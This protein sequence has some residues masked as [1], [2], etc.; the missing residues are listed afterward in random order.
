MNKRKII[1]LL[2]ILLYF[3]V[4]FPLAPMLDRINVYASYVFEVAFVTLVYF[5]YRGR[6]RFVLP[7]KQQAIINGV[8]ALIAG[9]VIYTLSTVL[10]L[11]IPFDLKGA[12]ILIFLLLVA[13]LLEEGVFRFAL[14]EP[15]SEFIGDKKWLVLAFTAAA[16]S[17]GH[18]FAYFFVSDDFRPFVIYQT[19]Y[20][21]FFGAYVGWLRLSTNSLVLPIG[22]H[23]LFN[24]GFYLAYC[25]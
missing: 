9:F 10:S 17:F 2:L 15:A 5:L 19:I 6:A 12:E 3:V 7:S 23:F 16:F 8:S 21:V 4:R 11:Q 13:P 14:W 1:S 18:F 20:T 22:F 25:F 24:V